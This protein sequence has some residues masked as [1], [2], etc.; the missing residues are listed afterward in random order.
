MNQPNN[1]LK[2]YQILTLIPIFVGLANNIQSRSEC[3]LHLQTETYF[4]KE[5]WID[6][7][8][9]SHTY[10]RLRLYTLMYIFRISR[11]TFKVHQNAHLQPRT[12]KTE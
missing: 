6:N 7:L 12:S 9:E 10:P 2:N 3:A 4:K 5:Y 8:S 11:M 1:L